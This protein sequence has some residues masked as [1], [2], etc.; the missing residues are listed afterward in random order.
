L[1]GEGDESDVI[2]KYKAFIQALKASG[3]TV[4]DPHLN[5][6]KDGEV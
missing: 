1:D 2:D 3:H 6:S 4:S 5:F